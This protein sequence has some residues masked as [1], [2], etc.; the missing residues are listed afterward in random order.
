MRSG[1]A[2]G[3]LW[4]EID[5]ESA[6]WTLPAERM[7]MR[8]KH[9]VPLSG[10]ALAVLRIAR[11]SSVLRDA[12]RCGACPDLVFPNHSGALLH[13]RALSEL[14]KPLG[15]AAV[16][17]GFRSSFCDWC[18]ETGVEFSVSEKCLAHSVGNKVT[19]SYARSSLF[20]RRV[21][22]ME[23]W[24]EYVCAPLAERDA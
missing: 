2:R 8:V 4:S 18:G 17:H 16:P 20:N 24:A 15:I 10:R 5:F 21:K 12:R 23:D 9:A 1:E 22:V 11:E 7:K 3:A 19:E 13:P 14:M 6:T